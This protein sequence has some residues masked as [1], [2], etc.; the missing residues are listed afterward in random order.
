MRK[1]SPS[2]FDALFD[3]A[4]Q[5]DAYW[6]DKALLDFCD[7]MRKLMQSQSVSKAELARRIGKSAPYVSKIFRGDENFTVATMVKLARAL[8][9]RVELR[10]HPDDGKAAPQSN[11]PE[12]KAAPAMVRRPSREVLPAPGKKQARARG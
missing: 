12:R 4:R 2:S 1:D 10:V 7:D 11:G 5:G 8:G 3:E 9:G 6:T